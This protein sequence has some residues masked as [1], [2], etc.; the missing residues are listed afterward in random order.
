MNSAIAKDIIALNKRYLLLVRQLAAQTQGR[1]GLIL[2]V[3]SEIANQ[4][5]RMTYDE[6]ELLA[7][8]MIAPCFSFGFTEKTFKQF[9]AS[10]TSENRHAYMTNVLLSRT[11]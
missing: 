10:N 9:C 5:K 3:P 1:G 4:V 8:A 11:K 2:G 7:E 6:I